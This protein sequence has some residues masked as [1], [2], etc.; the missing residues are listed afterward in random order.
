MH[1]LSEKHQKLL[2]GGAIVLFFIFSAFLFTAIGIPMVKHARNPE[3]FRAWIDAMGIWGRIAYIGMNVF[4]V[5]VAVVPGGPLEVAGGYAFGHVEATV[6]AIIG[7]A[8]GNA[9]VFLLVRFFGYRL[10]E[11]FFPMEK[12][13]EL[14][15]LSSSKKRNI[16]LSILF[17]V[18]GTPKDL[19]A[20][21]C[22]LTDIPFWTF[23]AIATFCRIPA[24]WGSTLGGNAAGE[25]SYV[26]AIVIIAAVVVFT[27]I[28]V[29]VY[30]F[31]VRHNNKE[32]KENEK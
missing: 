28:G 1:E 19:I 22:G 27:V 4:Q 5:L 26:S 24:V 15:F 11:A 2:S 30:A 25:K 7:M 29:G 13:R 10:V 14:K 31:V 12:I 18:P 21:F 9:A 16:L 3:D 23:M 20:Y 8:I 17:L 6:F 32:K